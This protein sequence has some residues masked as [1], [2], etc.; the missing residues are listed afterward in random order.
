MCTKEDEIEREL[1]DVTFGELH[2]ARSDGTSLF[3]QKN[4]KENTTKRANK[5]MYFCSS[6]FFLK[7]YLFPELGYVN[8]VCE[9]FDRLCMWNFCL[10]GQWKLVVQSRSVDSEKLYKLRKRCVS[11]FALEIARP[12]MYEYD[13]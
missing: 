5:N 3:H 9:V 6:L 11:L 7:K 13:M 4:S 8:G 1:A 12:S 10:T 2:K